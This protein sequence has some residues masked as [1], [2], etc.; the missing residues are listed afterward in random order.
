MLLTLATLASLACTLNYVDVG[1]NKGDSIEEFL[2]GQ[3]EYRL[4]VL[5]DAAMG[6]YWHNSPELRAIAASSCIYGFEPNPRWTSRLLEVQRNA[7]ELGVPHIEIQTQTALVSG[8]QKSMTL[9]DNGK[10][11]SVGASVV[12]STGDKKSAVAT[13]NIVEFLKKLRADVPTIIRMDVEASEYSL[14]RKLATSGLGSSHRIYVGVEWHRFIKEKALQGAAASH[15]SKLDK[16]MAHF[17]RGTGPVLD[18][19]APDPKH[20]STLMQTYEKVITLMLGAA[21][22]TMAEHLL[23]NV[24][25][26][27]M[28]AL[29]SR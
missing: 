15:F 5:L 19:K 23:F 24:T 4:K 14:L 26:A 17:N 27:E 7:T 20:P 9:S 22:I 25:R 28:E 12:A 18:V 11:D 2:R 1:S 29:Q 13:I 6:D 8:S 3:P 16:H 21:N 10:G